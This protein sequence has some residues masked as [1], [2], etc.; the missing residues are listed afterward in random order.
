[1]TWRVP[2]SGTPSVEWE[3]AFRGASESTAV[4]N[5]RN[6]QFERTA[7]SFRST[8]DDVPLWVEYIDKWVARANQARADVQE[9]RRRETARAEEQS[10]A[11][12]QRVIEANDKFRDL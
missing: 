1:V 4:A 10:G 9:E 11:R 8:E 12:R 7:L 5:S 2:L 6:V 3:H